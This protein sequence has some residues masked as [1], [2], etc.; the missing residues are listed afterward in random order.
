[1]ETARREA[2]LQGEEQVSNLAAGGGIVRGFGCEGVGSGAV[3][4][5][6]ENG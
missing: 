5:G 4:I 6:A 1:V 2:S 3:A